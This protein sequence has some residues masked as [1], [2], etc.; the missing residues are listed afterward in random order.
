MPSGKP[1]VLIIEDDLPTLAL[2]S[3]ELSAE[4]QVE[5]T[6]DE[7]E[8][9]QLAQ[10]KQVRAVVLE[11]GL[12]DG[13]GWG[14]FAQ[15]LQKLRDRKVPIVLCSSLDERRRGLN[16]GAAAYLVKPVLPTELHEVLHR[17]LALAPTSRPIRQRTG[18]E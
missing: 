15:L 5:G 12:C 8:A 2:Y 7:T 18:N 1:I 17:V 3:R 10:D 16:M 11:P 4:Y 14:L 9:L 6:L 13:N